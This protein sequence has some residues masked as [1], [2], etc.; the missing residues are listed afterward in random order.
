[1]KSG[2]ALVDRVRLLA[3]DL[4]QAGVPTGLSNVVDAVTA[5]RQVDLSSE[6]QVRLALRCT[7]IKRVEDE[8]L[9]DS[10][11]AARFAP[12]VPT[13]PF[14][15]DTADL[16][17][18]LVDALAIDDRGLLSALAQEA[19]QRHGGSDPQRLRHQ[20]HRTMRALRTQTLVH[21]ALRRRRGADGRRDD[22]T[23]RLDQAEIRDAL[24]HF[25][26]SLTGTVA[27]AMED[28]DIATASVVELRRL[29]HAVRPLARRLAARIS[30][31]RHRPRGALDIRRTMR[32]SLGAGG[33]PLDPLFRRRQP[34]RADLWLLC[35]VS[36]SVA[37]FA[38]FTIGLLSA[39]H[40]EVPRLR[41]FL[42]VDDIV[43][44]TGLL[45]ARTHDVDPF[46]IVAGAGAP[47]GGRRSNWGAVVKRFHDDHAA[48]LTRRSTILLTGDARS[49]D[50]DPGA[51]VLAELVQQTRGVWLLDPEPSTGWS[52]EET[53]VADYAAAG[54]HVLEVRTLAQLSAAIE[55]IIAG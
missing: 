13:P 37:E 2:T 19:V 44:V 10:L 39:I 54:V 53:A 4:R 41:S 5:L 24:D 8:A 29:R 49:H 7:L 34:H 14:R 55:H 16:R 6:E 52:L 48:G 15:E 47:L 45:A 27:V 50:H 23:E 40:D 20:R 36:G 38:R 51:A 28:I 26:A 21:D 22:T 33:V 30:R 17:D 11:F 12:P 3:G 25:L 32:R 46:A 18:R 9:F 31:R 35:D 43:E 1:M 42:F